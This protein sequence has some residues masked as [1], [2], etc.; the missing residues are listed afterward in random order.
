MQSRMSIRAKLILA[1]CGLVSVLSL[2]GAVAIAND[3]V[4]AS[5]PKK[6]NDVVRA[7]PDEK[8]AEGPSYYCDFRGSP[9]PKE[10]KNQLSPKVTK[11]EAEGLRITFSPPSPPVGGGALMLQLKSIEDLQKLEDYEIT[12][13]IELIPIAPAP[14]AAPAAKAPVPAPKAP[15]QPKALAAAD[16]S[17]GIYLWVTWGEA[18]IGRVVR[19]DGTQEIEA[20]VTTPNNS[21]KPNRQ[22]VAEPCRENVLRLRLKRTSDILHFLWAPGASGDKFE[23]LHKCQ[24]ERLIGEPTLSFVAPSTTDGR[25]AN[26]DV[27]VIDFRVSR[28]VNQTIAPNKIV[29]KTALKTPLSAKLL[30]AFGIVSA[31]GGVWYFVR[32]RGSLAEM[33]PTGAVGSQEAAESQLAN[34][35]DASSFVFFPCSVCGNTLQAGADMAGKKA[36]CP[37]CQNVMQV[38][39]PLPVE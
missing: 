20:A 25:A 28:P 11:V 18:K 5:A 4:G 17:M 36:K 15:V 12:A 31:L 38:P 23:E 37:Q 16:A 33:P 9:I 6:A 24:H 19:A 22:I 29:T 30:A 1:T 10:F 13:T 34:S 14:K 35:Q 32:E 2:L 3:L 8:A 7:A 39:A 27:R 26:L 21:P